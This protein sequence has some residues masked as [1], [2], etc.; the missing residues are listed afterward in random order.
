VVIDFG[1]FAAECDA[2]G[3]G[4]VVG[5]PHYMAPESVRADIKAGDAH[6]A[7]IY[8]LGVIAFELLT[9]IVP[10][11]GANYVEILSG[12][13]NLAVPDVVVLR[14]DTPEPL[15]DLVT[16][17]LQKD[18]D[19]RPNDVDTILWRLRA[20]R[21]DQVMRAR[22]TTFTVLLVDDDPNARIL[23]ELIVRRSVPEADISTVS[24][25]SAA[26]FSATQ[27]PPHLMLL[28]LDLPTMNGLEVCLALRGT[29][30]ADHTAIVLVS[31][32]AREDDV[33]LLRHLGVQQF[34][35]KGPSMARN[36][37][38]AINAVRAKG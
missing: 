37:T 18:P 22:A 27:H 3:A 19:E 20:I 7:D 29:R 38:A 32:R 2:R 21:G 13:V 24:D 28:D 16:D 35:E 9:G 12:H 34:V 10:F 15:A 36:L 30:A 11:D 8:A 4:D 5:T 31:G 25:G 17:L 1:I 6:M 26:V 33:E 14:E 23:T